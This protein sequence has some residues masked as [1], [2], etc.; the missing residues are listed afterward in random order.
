[1]EFYYMGFKVLK[2]VLIFPIY[3]EDG[4]IFFPNIGAH[5]PSHLPY[6]LDDHN[7]EGFL[8]PQ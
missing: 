1:M 6:I 5:F 7:P 4:V 2:N 3:S 8:W